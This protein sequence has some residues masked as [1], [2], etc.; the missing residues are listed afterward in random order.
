[1]DWLT[2]MSTL[3]GHL[4]WPVLILILALVF[5]RHVVALIP[6][7]RELEYG[8]LKVTFARELTRRSRMSST[9]DSTSSWAAERAICIGAHGDVGC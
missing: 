3:V 8:K 1:M 4:A 9:G 6:L 2:F 7:L 5:R